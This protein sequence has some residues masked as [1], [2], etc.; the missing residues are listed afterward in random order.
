MSW[1]LDTDRP[2]FIQLVEILKTDI[3]S[4]KLSPGD[5][6][7][8]VRDLAQEAAVNPNTMQRAMTELERLGLVY[9]ERTSG[10]FVT[11]DTN[12]IE[13]AKKELASRRIQEF[14]SA[15]EGLGYAPDEITELMEGQQVTDEESGK[16]RPLR[17]GDIVILLRSLS[18][19]ADEITSVLMDAG[20]PAHT[21]SKTGY[22]MTTEVQTV[23]N[24]LR[25]LN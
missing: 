24:Y 25:I 7:S 19:Y 23:L 12:R 17:Y 10:R 13:E 16:L 21:A 20:I 1:K 18:G 14:L 22:F 15:M 4:G 6:I 3:L 2:I 8:T 11:E 9:T 5:K